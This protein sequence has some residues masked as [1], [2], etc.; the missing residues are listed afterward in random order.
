MT[1]LLEEI[2]NNLKNKSNNLQLQSGNNFSF[3][4]NPDMLEKVKAAAPSSKLYWSKDSNILTTK[5]ELVNITMGKF[6]LG[7]CFQPFVSS[8]VFIYT[9]HEYK[10]CFQIFYFININASISTDMSKFHLL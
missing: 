7:K 2:G 3:D 5:E 10:I 1:G 9:T 6:N 4:C 8:V